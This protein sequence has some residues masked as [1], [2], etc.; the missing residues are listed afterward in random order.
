LKISGK[1]VMIYVI[2]DFPY[3]EEF[4]KK[5]KLAAL[6]CCRLSGRRLR[7]VFRKGIPA[8]GE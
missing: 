8:C 4:M 3:K 7:G 6:V 2:W 1:E 5:I